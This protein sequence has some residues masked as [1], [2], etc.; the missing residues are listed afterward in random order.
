MKLGL[1][2]F[3][4]QIPPW[5]DRDHAALYADTLDLVARADEAGFDS[6]WLAEHHAATDGYNPSVLPMLA[7]FAART[8]RIELG[9]AVLLAPFH[10]PL[11]VAED[12]AVVDNISGGRLNLGL[13]LGWAPEEYR[14]FQA[15]S[16]GRGRRLAEFA[17]V[18]R[19]AWTQERFTFGGEFYDY[20]DVAVMPKPARTP[21]LWLGGTVDAALDR[22]ARY[23]DGYF[24]PSTHG[25]D[26]VA[27]R[28]EAVVAARARAGATGPFRFGTFVPVGIGRDADEGW[29]SIRDGVMHVRGSYMLWAQ[30][31]R[32]V[33]GARDAVAPFEEQIRASTLVGSPK[34]IVARLERMA[35][36]VEGLG[37]SEVFFSAGLGLPGMPRDAVAAAIDAFASEVLPAFR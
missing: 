28:A 34:D 30:G 15:P 3:T 2:Q 12:A 20:R 10:D 16:K 21:R 17:Q 24:P 5:D 23:G 7:A 26:G 32:D 1:G 6:V 11:R 19:A 22:A 31:E 37:F 33:S 18:L 14:M 25:V 27:E 36:D 13:G 9:S 4:L 29:A 35:E 8:R